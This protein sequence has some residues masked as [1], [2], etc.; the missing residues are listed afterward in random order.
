MIG[1]RVNRAART[2]STT[3]RPKP[4]AIASPAD[5]RDVGLLEGAVDTGEQ[6]AP[7]DLFLGPSG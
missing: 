7:S 6:T 2:P 4:P 1:L 5:K 3:L